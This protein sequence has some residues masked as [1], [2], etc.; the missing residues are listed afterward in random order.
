MILAQRVRNTCVQA[1]LDAYENARQEGIC[2]EGAFEV[3]IGVLQQ[4]DLKQI[5]QIKKPSD[6]PC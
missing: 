4:L 3:A 1:A 5:I 2:A 6:L